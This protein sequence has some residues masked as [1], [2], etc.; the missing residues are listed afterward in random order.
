M[1]APL[2]WAAAAALPGV[3]LGQSDPPDVVD[4]ID[5]QRS[6]Q[7]YLQAHTTTIH[8]NVLDG[9]S[10]YQLAVSPADSPTGRVVR[11]VYA[12]YGDSVSLMTMP[13]AHQEAAPF[14]A[15]IGGTNSAFLAAAPN[16]AFDSWLTVGET[17]GNVHDD[18]A[19]I[20]IDFDLWTSDTDGGL[21]VDDGAVFFMDPSSG[22]RMDVAGQDPVV[23]AQ[24]TISPATPGSAARTATIGAQGRSRAD[25]IS[26]PI[27]DW[28]QRGLVFTID[29]GAG[30]G[31]AAPSPS[32]PAHDDHSGAIHSSNILTHC[33][34][35]QVSVL[36]RC[37]ADCD[38][39]NAHL[40]AYQTI[41]ADCHTVSSD[42][43]DQGLAS[44]QMKQCNPTTARPT[45]PPGPHTTR[46]SPPP[47]RPQP[48]PT[49]PPP[50]PP[51]PPPP[52][53]P[54]QS[55]CTIDVLHDGFAAI[56][57][58]C[59]QGNECESGIPRTC[60]DQCANMVLTFRDRCEDVLSTLPAGFSNL[61]E[62]ALVCEGGSKPPST[63]NGHTIHDSLGGLA[64]RTGSGV[65]SH[66][67]KHHRS[68]DAS[69]LPW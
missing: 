19:A 55:E 25:G 51:P 12:I 4:P 33:S 6:D 32:D 17:N 26:E 9:M 24:I 22:P 38:G 65:P 36:D 57:S 43:Q 3:C 11:N 14:G 40:H 5:V 58:L 28:D 69:H 8:T 10:T 20:G 48:L 16:T 41:V 50:V 68:L 18:V 56:Q 44:D 63:P 1:R 46:P 34:E 61:D 30:G 49:P 60:N 47:T 37:I 15:N 59:C 35:L 62:F 27:A 52:P 45:L 67:R 39:C 29:G 7:P 54:P 2:L 66:W 31:T 13:P 23:V 53:P 64:S 21:S 42:N